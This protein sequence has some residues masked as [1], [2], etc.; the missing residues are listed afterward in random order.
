MLMNFLLHDKHWATGLY[1]I[2]N[3]VDMLPYPHTNKCL[4]IDCDGFIEKKV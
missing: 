1:R 4:I 2:V 3:K